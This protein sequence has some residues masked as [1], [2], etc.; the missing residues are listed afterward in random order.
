MK[1]SLLF[2]ALLSGCAGSGLPTAPP[3]QPSPA[4]PAVRSVHADTGKGRAV[5]NLYYYQPHS[6]RPP[7]RIW[8]MSRREKK[9]CEALAWWDNHHT[10]TPASGW[11]YCSRGRQHGPA[12]IDGMRAITPRAKQPAK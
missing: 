8:Y 2:A 7:W 10:D 11:Y 3:S 6:D 1:R 12:G 9:N 4:A 5:W